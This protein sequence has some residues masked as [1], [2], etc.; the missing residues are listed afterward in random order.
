MREN[1]YQKLMEQIQVPMRLEKQVMMAARKQ[2]HCAVRQKQPV[3]RVA[4][5]AALALMLVLGGISLR[6]DGLVR[7]PER[8]RFE[9]PCPI[10]LK[11][12]CEFGLTAYAADTLPA[13]NGNLVLGGGVS[14]DVVITTTE[15]NPERAQY[16]NYRFR[17][18][19]ENIETLT[20]SIDRCGL[21]RTRS[22][23]SLI[24]VLENSVAEPYD[25]EAVYG[26]WIPPQ[27]WVQGQDASVLDGAELT[28]T[29]LFTNGTEQTSVYHLTIQRLLVSE[30][31]DGTE[32]LVPALEGSDQPG[33]SGLYLEA[34]SSVW[35]HWPVEGANTVSL[36]NRY[37][38]RWNPGGKTRTFHAG[39]DIPA[40]CGTVVTAAAGGTVTEAGYDPA[41]GNYLIL[42]HG[43]GMETVYAQCL[44][45]SVEEGDNVAAG[46]PIAVVG[47]TGLSTGPHLH[48][49][50][51]Q[52][53]EAQNPVAYFDREVRE[54]LS[55]R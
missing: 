5:C 38:Y 48:F 34:L 31:E 44:S 36:S 52:N 37:G 14:D 55:M 3:W 28:V 16:T 23:Q 8:V 35:F 42:D 15:L 11:L 13:G 47:S 49:E 33:I 20:L 6:P 25:P 30:N 4:V 17:I 51:R 32:L 53:G 43:N 24:S 7:Q 9:E 12:A 45:L 10:G 22:G 27:V 40:E 54:T 1:E 2:E 50:V 19:G 18:E 46:G 41:Q 29:A 21:Y 39:I 26:L